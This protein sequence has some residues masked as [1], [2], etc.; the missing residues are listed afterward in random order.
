M[1]DDEKLNWRRVTVSDT[2]ALVLGRQLQS[3]WDERVDEIKEPNRAPEEAT[4]FTTTEP[5][6]TT[7][8]Y[9]SPG[10]AVLLQDFVQRHHGVPCSAR[11]NEDLTLWVGHDS[12]WEL[13]QG[14]RPD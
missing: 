1:S 12:G 3:A 13:L 4:V 14:R 5:E 9:F 6:E 7:D 10:A 11:S 2:D 8:F